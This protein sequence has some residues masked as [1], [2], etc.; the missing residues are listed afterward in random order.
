MTSSG[1]SDVCSVRICMLASTRPS[2]TNGTSSSM[3][4]SLASNSSSA[5]ANV[6]RFCRSGA[7]Q[8]SRSKVLRSDPCR[9]VAM[10][11]I[12]TKSIP[13][14]MRVL[15]SAR[16]RNSA[17]TPGVR[18]S[19]EL[20]ELSVGR[21]E[22]G[23]ALGGSQPKVAREQS[24]VDVRGRGLRLQLEPPACR[25]KSGIE[26][27]N[28]GVGSGPLKLSHCGLG[29]AKPSRQLALGQPGAQTGLADE[30]P[31]LGH[32]PIVVLTYMARRQSGGSDS[33][34]PG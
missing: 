18:Q 9:T 15:S 1:P 33:R 7:G 24:L 23:E 26:R 12:T 13:C 4:L 17:G 14:A 27:G 6:S 19:A 32:S 31:T 16:G 29:L 10:P 30:F 22:C 21:L 28:G 34:P 2:G 20:A 5:F 25:S 11:P 8:M 3:P